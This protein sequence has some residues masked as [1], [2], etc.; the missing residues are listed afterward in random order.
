MSIDIVAKQKVYVIDDDPE[1]RDLLTW[2]LA[3]VNI[4]AENYASAEQF[5]QDY[6]PGQPGCIVLDLRMPGMSGLRLFDHLRALGHHCPI[7]ILTG[8]GDIAMAVRAMREGAF[9][10]IEKPFSEQQLLERIQDALALDRQ[11]QAQLTVIAEIKER[12]ALLTPRERDVLDLLLE[13]KINKAIAVELGINER[14]VETHRYNVMEK[15]KVKSLGELLR[16]LLPRQ[17]L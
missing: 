14:T 13:G 8:H 11:Q 2:L 9:D 1:L 10:F 6:E 4:A 3:S 5:L 7:I 15:M 17:P 12:L 16:M